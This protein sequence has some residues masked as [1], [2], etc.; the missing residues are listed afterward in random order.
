MKVQ[1]SKFRQKGIYHSLI[2]QFGKMSTTN[3]L[4]SEEQNEKDK[5]EEMCEFCEEKPCIA[6]EMKKDIEEFGRELEQTCESNKQIRFHLY[7][8]AALT[9]WGHLGAGN[10]KEL[11]LCLQSDIRVL[12]PSQE[13]IGYREKGGEG[14]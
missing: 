14:D 9:L 11:P 6:D 4:E 3:Q 8:K 10:R 2:S 7:R 12:Y 1:T 5:E 13:Y